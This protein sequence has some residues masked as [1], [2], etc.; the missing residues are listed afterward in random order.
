MQKSHGFTWNAGRLG[1]F[2]G[3]YLLALETPKY[4][5]FDEAREWLSLYVFR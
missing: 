5:N 4:L 3:Q 2:G 1:T